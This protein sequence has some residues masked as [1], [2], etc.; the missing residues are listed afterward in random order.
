MAIKT[1]RKS[2]KWIT[3]IGTAKWPRL[4]VPDTKF[5][6]DGEYSVEIIFEGDTA[7]QVVEQL[8]QFLEVSREEAK[9]QLANKPA[10]LKTLQVMLPYEE[11]EDGSIKIR[12]RKPALYRAQ[13]GT[14][15]ERKIIVVDSKVK[16]I[17]PREV[18]NGSLIRAEI[19]VKPFYFPPSN[20]YGV[21]LKDLRGVQLIKKAESSF[22]AVSFEPFEDGYTAEEPENAEN[23]AVEFDEDEVDF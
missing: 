10:K 7:V 16:P 6:P 11:L 20:S 14:V 2:F 17:D 18:T 3:P 21:S 15:F 1:T 4:A 13:D 19:R 9:K 22:G 8:N 12:I 5:N 23:E